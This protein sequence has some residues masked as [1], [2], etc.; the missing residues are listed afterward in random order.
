MLMNMY[1]GI[2]LFSLR[3]AIDKGA[4]LN[5]ALLV[6][7]KKL[8][9]LLSRLLILTPLLIAEVLKPKLVLLIQA[10]ARRHTCVQHLY[11]LYIFISKLL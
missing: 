7:I 8:F 4:P 10:P 6:V 2:L 9:Y 5:E 3:S 11:N 1:E